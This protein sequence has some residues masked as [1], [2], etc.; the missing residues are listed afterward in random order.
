MAPLALADNDDH[1]LAYSLGASLGERLRQEMPG[2]QLD[3]LVEGLKQSY[4]GQP[5]KLDKARMQAVL[6]Q[7][8]AQEGDA[9]AQS[10][11][12]PKRVSWLMNV[13]VMGCT[14]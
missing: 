12:P 8:E 4:Q 9:A 3:A 5:L 7:H 14:N 10:C 1:D 2:L 13:G 11:R 6:Q